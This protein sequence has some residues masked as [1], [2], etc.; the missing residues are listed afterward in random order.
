MKDEYLERYKN[1]SKILSV[2]EI[3]VMNYLVKRV[4]NGICNRRILCKYF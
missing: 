4:F 1:V 3:D 2:I